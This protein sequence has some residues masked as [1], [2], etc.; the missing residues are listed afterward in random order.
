MIL[1]VHHCGPRAANTSLAYLLSS[2][3]DA[4]RTATLHHFDRC[5]KLAWRLL[6]L[7]RSNGALT[8]TRRRRGRFQLFQT[9]DIVKDD[10]STATA[11]RH[12]VSFVEF[13]L[14]LTLGVGL[15]CDQAIARWS[16]GN[17]S[18]FGRLDTLRIVVWLQNRAE[19]CGIL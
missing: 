15:L 3:L 17:I 6:H 1:L 2:S 16:L 13:C 10:L 12:N 4:Y 7:W 18:H 8:L 14:E 19:L 11:S 5:V 9:L